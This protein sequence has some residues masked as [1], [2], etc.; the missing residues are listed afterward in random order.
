V[1][2]KRCSCVKKLL[3]MSARRHSANGI[4][5][6][7]CDRD[8]RAYLQQ[9]SRDRLPSLGCAKNCSRSCLAARGVQ[10]GRGVPAE[11]QATDSWRGRHRFLSILLNS[12]LSWSGSARSPMSERRRSCRVAEPAFLCGPAARCL[13]ANANGFRGF[14]IFC[15]GVTRKA[16]FCR[17]ASALFAIESPGLIQS[18][19]YRT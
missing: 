19:Y 4:Q 11:C 12:Y 14:G 9:K 18:R 3:A 1:Q 17:L 5:K 16:S 8:P 2:M 13:A 10:Q 6:S 15:E 7:G